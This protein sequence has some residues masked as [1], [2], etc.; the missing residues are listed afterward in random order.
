MADSLDIAKVARLTGLTSRALRFYEAR[1]LI[2]P[3]RSASGR[4]HYGPAELERLHQILALK[5]AG[6][7]LAQIERLSAG[8]KLDLRELVIAQIE[9]LDAQAKEIAKAKELLAA[10]L[11]RID[12]SEPIDVA[13]FCSLIRQ[14]ETATSQQQ[15]LEMAS[16]FMTENQRDAFEQVRNAFPGDLD[17]TAQMAKFQSLN[18]RIKAALPLDPAS[19]LA[20]RFLDE[21]DMMLKPFLALFSPEAKAAARSLRETIRQG[22]LPPPIDAEV[23]HFYQEA[24]RARREMASREP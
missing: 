3:L 17:R 21:R 5:R 4:R 19:E 16:S 18:A 12:H 14:G 1:G 10:I 20:Q 6:L 22:G 8:R 7:S 24:T 13:T 9:A 23:D 11:S 2:R 15:W